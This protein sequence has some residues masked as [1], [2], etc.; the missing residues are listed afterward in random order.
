M[1]T[2]MRLISGL[3]G[4]RVGT[5]RFGN[6][7]FETRNVVR[8]FNHTRR[9]VVFAGRA[10]AT[11]VPPEWH[12]WLHHATPDPLDE[13]QRYAW[14][15]DH[16]PNLTGTALAYRPKGHDYEGGKRPASYGDYDAWTPGS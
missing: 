11:D 7:Y 12:G 15:Q 13:R 6:I 3:K 9:W 14:Q 5:D 4:R 2:F 8:G 16:K 10:E 1:S